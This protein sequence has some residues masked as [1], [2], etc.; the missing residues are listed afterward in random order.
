MMFI[1]IGIRDMSASM[2]LHQAQ[3]KYPFDNITGIFV[4]FRI[5]RCTGTGYIQYLDV[6]FQNP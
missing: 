4:Y 2:G 5:F 1:V 3:Q 6:M